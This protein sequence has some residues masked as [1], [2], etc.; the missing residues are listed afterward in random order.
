MNLALIVILMSFFSFSC[1]RI[2]STN[3]RQTGD[4]VFFHSFYSDVR[5]VNAYII[6]KYNTFN[7]NLNTFPFL[8]CICIYIS[9]ISHQF[10][11]FSRLCSCVCACYCSFV[12]DMFRSKR[13]AH[14]EQIDGTYSWKMFW[15]TPS[16]SLID[17]N[18]T[19]IFLI[20]DTLSYSNS[21]RWSCVVVVVVVVAVFYL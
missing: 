17:N 18:E 20:T 14:M 15:D 9:S 1:H 7:R 8:F 2:S 11:F 3:E 4:S 16:G 5:S 10:F 19:G 6:F 21:S 13:L 12:F